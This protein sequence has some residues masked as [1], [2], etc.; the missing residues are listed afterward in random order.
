MQGLLEHDSKI[1]MARDVQNS[2]PLHLAARYGHLDAVKYL[3]EEVK[4]D[5]NCTDLNQRFPLHDACQNG[6]LNVIKYFIEVHDCSGTPML[7]GEE[8]REREEEQWRER[9]LENWHRDEQRRGR[10]FQQHR[11]LFQLF[12][13]G[14]GCLEQQEPPG[15]Q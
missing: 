15:E 8:E 12:I 9:E 5:P 10:E 2:T 6:H 7:G 1:L 14:L 13:Q 3:V 4:C 11:S